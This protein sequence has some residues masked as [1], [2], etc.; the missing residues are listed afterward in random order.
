MEE[1]KSDQYDLTEHGK[2]AVE[3]FDEATSR[4]EQEG[5]NICILHGLE[6]AMIGTAVRNGHAVAVYER[7]LCIRCIADGMDSAD[8]AELHKDEYSEEELS[9]PELIDQLK[10][11]DA[12]EFYEANTVRTLPYI[13]EAEPIIV[14]GFTPDTHRWHAFL[15]QDNDEVTVTCYGQT[16]K[17][18]TRK[19]AIDFYKDCVRHSEGAEQARYIRIVTM[20]EDGEMHATDTE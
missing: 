2:L 14:E 3:R 13:G 6:K 10:L 7:G 15:N 20:L 1:K 8:V 5:D 19:E 9:N 12:E 4:D 11:Q 16:S 17:Y 18:R